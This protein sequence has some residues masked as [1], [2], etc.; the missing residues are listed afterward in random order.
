MKLAIRDTA[1]QRDL[2]RTWAYMPKH[3]GLLLAVF[4]QLGIAYDGERL[5]VRLLVD[6]HAKAATHAYRAGLVR[7]RDRK[8]A[9]RAETKEMNA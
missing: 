1:T 7:E 4:G 5:Y 8:R 2:A 3:D 9:R 6:V